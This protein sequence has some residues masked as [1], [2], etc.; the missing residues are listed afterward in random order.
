MRAEHVPSFW[1]G[2]TAA[3]AIRRRLA[4][5]HVLT[6]RIVAAAHTAITVTDQRHMVG[7]LAALALA[8]TDA[9]SAERLAD[10]LL[11]QEACPQDLG[12]GHR[13]LQL[14]VAH[15]CCAGLWDQRR[16][17]AIRAAAAEL[18]G[19]LRHGTSSHNP[20][21]VQNN[22]WGVTHGGALLAALVA[23]CEEETRW[24]LGRCLAFAQ[25]LGPAGLY[26]E[27]LGYQMYTLS[28][29]LPALA[30]A[31]RRGLVDLPEE[32]PWIRRLAE[33]LFAF[34]ALRPSVSDTD[35]PPEGYGTMLSWNDAGL[36]WQSCNVS[37]LALTYAD[38]VKRAALCAWS[39]RLEA[40]P[41]ENAPLYRG[42]EGWPFALAL[43]PEVDAPEVPLRRHVSDHRQ[44][45][46]VFRDRWQDQDDTL[47]GCYARATHVGGHT[48]DDGGS[49][50]LM[51]LGH[52]W[53][54]GGGQA[55]GDAIWQSVVTPD[56][57]ASCKRKAGCGAVI[58]DEATGHGGIYGMDLRRVSHAYHERY[59]AISGN[60][61][62][63]VAA[64]AAILDLI[65]DHLN[66]S[67]TWRIT[68][69]PGLTCMPD[70][71][72]SGFRLVA[73][74]GIQAC[75]RFLGQRPD[76]VRHEQTPASSRTFSNDVKTDY[77]A[78]PM[79]AAG[80][81]S[82]P[83]L[84][85]M[86]AVAIERGPAPPIDLSA[87]IDL[88][89]G[90]SAWQRPFGSAVPADYDLLRAGTLSRWADGRRGG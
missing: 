13:G 89:I 26:H 41:Q 2:P 12:L 32:L 71:D 25:H 1:F 52:D 81:S 86:V 9:D 28:H 17:T 83:H 65:D 90:G 61:A 62:H 54:I 34:T 39:Q 82:R 59:A 53:I 48:H 20:H 79:V 85:I 11:S 84:A 16:L 6:M 3:A 40:G 68:H 45:L 70:A 24:A 72:G 10:H 47:L 21:A 38:P 63:G 30:A 22:W 64:V 35:S 5:G 14:A 23:G 73:A 46:A 87:G 58:W 29:L 33:S 67:W 44:G 60:R 51:A 55:R 15:E 75:F 57:I 27:G 66:R 4:E 77:P 56:D 31:H 18:V 76:W 43:P 50:R 37:P 7:G 49:V 80:F 36:A 88:A 69:E 19:R 78:R 42:W 74:D 8:E